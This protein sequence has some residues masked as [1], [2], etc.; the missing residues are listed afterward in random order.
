M[1]TTAPA[2][3]PAALRSRVATACRV[4]GKMGLTRALRG[5]IS[6]RLPGT[7]RIFVRARGPAE[8]GVRYTE[9]NEVI[10]VD[11]DG[12]PVAGI[13][14]GLRSPSEIWIHTE[15]YRAWAEVNAVL[16]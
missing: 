1:T 9:E 4:V 8:S 15:I 13:P 16:H 14:K 2:T 5:H 11:L 3:D 7:N 6:A 10:E 12:K